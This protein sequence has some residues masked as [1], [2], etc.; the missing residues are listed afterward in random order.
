M[1]RLSTPSWLFT[2]RPEDASVPPAERACLTPR[3]EALLDTVAGGGTGGTPF[4]VMTA[5]LSNH[6][7]HDGQLP[8]GFTDIVRTLLAE[9]SL[10]GS[11]ALRAHTVEGEII[12]ILHLGASVDTLPA[13]ERSL[14]GPCEA[15]Q[16]L[17]GVALAVAEH[18]GGFDPSE[19][20]AVE[21]AVRGKYGID[22]GAALSPDG[23][24]AAAVLVAQFVEARTRETICSDPADQV[25]LFVDAIAR[26]R[27]GVV[28]VL[29]PV[30][31]RPFVLA[32]ASQPAEVPL[33]IVEDAPS[34]LEAVAA[35]PSSMLEAA[36]APAL[37]PDPVVAAIESEPAAAPSNG[38]NGAEHHHEIE[39]ET[40]ARAVVMAEAAP[41][42]PVV[43]GVAY[44][45]D[46]ATG[47][48]VQVM[49]A[50][51]TQGDVRRSLDARGL[52]HS[53]PSIYATVARELHR[54]E[55]ERGDVIALEFRATANA[56]NAI[57]SIG[58][59]AADPSSLAL[60]RTLVDLSERGTMSRA[61]AVERL[62]G[63]DLTRL[64]SRGV[65]DDGVLA[66]LANGVVASPG[67]ACG[68][69]AFS[70]AQALAYRRS[71][72]D[73]VLVVDRAAAESMSVLDLAVAQGVL[74][75]GGGISSRVARATRRLG[76]P[77]LVLDDAHV[78]P[79]TAV[80]TI[81]AG[82]VL[83]GT[84]EELVEGSLVTIDTRSASLYA[85]E[86]PLVE[87]LP[88]R[89]KAMLH[90]WRIREL[91]RERPETRTT[92]AEL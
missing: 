43:C 21:A 6:L 18:V 29:E 11:L 76:I 63:L 35:E 72:C 55:S 71:P 31:V 70:G 4:I 10:D 56:A 14:G 28:F 90:S 74:L 48:A 24:R 9:L 16:A 50:S 77:C 25:A 30:E 85:G 33:P 32:A 51:A 87:L 80:V 73:V 84:V 40:A 5:R 38:V 69:L 83:N 13:L 82:T 54:L 2:S 19:F 62:K 8:V 37:E 3:T 52:R 7:L 39:V 78:D 58:P 44:S 20:D 12:E 65:L 42:D 92:S 34:L 53:H 49:E 79:H 81:H 64:R 59:V 23:A 22:D 75:L 36:T 17:R 27:S 66:P 60:L 41:P 57:E 26:K 88:P 68:R 86:L 15:A 61:Q 1:L 89:E 46:P 91:A 47:E 67:A 45:R